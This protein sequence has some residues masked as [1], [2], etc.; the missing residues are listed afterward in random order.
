MGRTN[1]V[2]DDKLVAE[3]RRLTGIKT[4]RALVDYSLNELRR[5]KKQ[6]RLL[7]L[8]GKIEWEGDLNA[9]REGRFA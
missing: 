7:E 9:M 5:R 2:L 4:T 8:E 1:I 3:C 6:L